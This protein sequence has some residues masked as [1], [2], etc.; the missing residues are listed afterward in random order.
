MWY[1]IAHA[2][3]GPVPRVPFIGL[4]PDVTSQESTMPHAARQLPSQVSVPLRFAAAVVVCALLALVCTIAEQASH[5]AV[6]TA[7]RPAASARRS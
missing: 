6:Q 7:A 5:E 1:V 2:P 4:E 3:R